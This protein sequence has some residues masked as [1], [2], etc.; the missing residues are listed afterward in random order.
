MSKRR[1]V[2]IIIGIFVLF[3][4]YLHYSTL[5]TIYALHNVYKEFYYIPIFLGAL[6]FGLRGALLI[7]LFVFVFEIPFVSKGWTGAFASEVS[8]LLHLGLQGLFAIFAGYLVDRE[9]K[10]REQAEK[11]RCLA[12]MWTGRYCNRA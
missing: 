11:E 7:Y 4:T 5:P 3:I 9:R 8:R 2:S 10:A 12:R 1:Y 6:A